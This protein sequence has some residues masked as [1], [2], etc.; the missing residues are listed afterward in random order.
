MHYVYVSYKCWHATHSVWLKLIPS[1]FFL[2]HFLHIFSVHLKLKK[3]PPRADQKKEKCLGK[4]ND[5]DW[6]QICYRELNSSIK[7][8]KKYTV[9]HDW[10]NKFMQKEKEAKLRKRQTED[11]CNPA[12]NQCKTS[13]KWGAE[14]EESVYEMD[15]EESVFFFFLM[16][17]IFGS[18][19]ISLCW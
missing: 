9:G 14:K 18:F 6:K 4:V 15:R 5:V 17:Q 13:L 10:D 1:S 3:N 12:L 8:G 19:N 7:M 2:Y 16:D 11:K